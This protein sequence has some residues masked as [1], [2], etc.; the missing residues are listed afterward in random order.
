MPMRTLGRTGAQVSV[1]GFGAGSRFL[2]YS[3]ERAIEAL[4]RALDLGI[5]YIDTA[6][7][8]GKGRS[9]RLI[10]EAIR[11]RR[12]SVV[13]A[14]KIES[15]KGDEVMRS[16][17]GSLKRLRTDYFDVLHIHNLTGAQDLAAL[18]ARGGAIEA[19]HKLRDQK[20]AR[21][22]GVTCHADPVAL[23]AAL[24]RHDFDCTQ[25]ALNAGLSG[26]GW[27][28]RPEVSFEAVALPVAVERKMGAIAMKVFAQDLLAGEAPPETLLRY[29]LSLPVAAAVV[30]MPTLE[31]LEEDVAAARRFEPMPEREMRELSGAISGKHKVALDRHFREHVDG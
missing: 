16:V 26:S 11:A 6:Q 23:K 17:E 1:L 2:R 15:R 19:L 18:E 14:D 5:N 12:N 20:V 3:H 22:I 13:L 24:E 30:G 31:H 8:Y 9:E 7:E 27:N 29:T 25:M 21:A 10:G 4:T 28:Q